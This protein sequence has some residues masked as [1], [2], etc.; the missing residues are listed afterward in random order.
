MKAQL[1]QKPDLQSPSSFFSVFFKDI[2]ATHKYYRQSPLISLFRPHLPHLIS[3]TKHALLCL[4]IWKQLV[5]TLELPSQGTL[6]LRKEMENYQRKNR[7]KYIHQKTN[8][9]PSPSTPVSCCRNSQ[10][11]R[12]TNSSTNKMHALLVPNLLS[13]IVNQNSHQ[14]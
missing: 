13:G 6:V 4:R 5:K 12:I 2:P 9:S 7:H 1:T 11:L 14:I 10:P 8:D 3:W